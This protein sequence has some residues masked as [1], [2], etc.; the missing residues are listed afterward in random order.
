MES[1]WNKGKRFLVVYMRVLR[2]LMQECSTHGMLMRWEMSGCKQARR[3]PVAESGNRNH[4]SIP[5]PRFLRRP[6]A[7]NSFNPVDG[8]NFKNLGADQQRLQISE[9][10]FDKFL[11]PHT[12]SCWKIRFRTE[13]CSCGNFHSD[14]MLRIKYVEMVNSVDDLKSSRSVKGFSFFFLMSSCSTERGICPDKHYP[15]LP[16]REIGQSGGTKSPKKQT[17]SSVE[18]RSLT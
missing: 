15:Q 10:H 12:F 16:R 11:A 3:E 1:A 4:D 7:R 8:R 2:N 6:S 17:D 5:T 14:A 13:V 9:L 18:D